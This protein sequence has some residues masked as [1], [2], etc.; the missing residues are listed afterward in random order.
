MKDDGKRTYLILLSFGQREFSELSASLKGI[1]EITERLSGGDCMLAWTAPRATAAGLLVRTHQSAQWIA[2]ELRSPG[3][4]RLL[5][6]RN[7]KPGE[8]SPMRTGDSLLVLEVGEDVHDIALSAATSWLR[9][10]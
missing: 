7:D 4:H 5:G 3:E 6:N 9:R 1:K 10:R 8:S 2:S